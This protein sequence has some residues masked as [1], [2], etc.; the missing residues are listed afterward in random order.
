MFDQLQGSVVSKND[1]RTCYHHLR[2][3][4]DDIPKTTFNSRY[5]R[6][7]FI[8]KSFGLTNTSTIL[9]ELMNKVFREY[10]D[11]FIIVFIDDILLYFELE[12]EYEDHW[13]KIVPMLRAH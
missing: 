7:E 13:R 2:I 9:M 11:A 12:A 1:L 10:L 3:K 4:E 5:G 8:L 6:Y